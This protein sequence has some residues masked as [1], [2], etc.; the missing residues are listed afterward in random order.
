MSDPSRR[1]EYT[2]RLNR[3]L[4]HI[5]THLG[6]ELTL[7]ELARVACFSKYHFHRLFRSLLGEN[8]GQFI[9]R[10]RLERAAGYLRQEPHKPITRIAYD[11]GFASSAAF[12]RA[13]R[14]HFRCSPS[15]F[16]RRPDAPARNADQASRNPGIAVSNPEKALPPA[17][18]HI[19]Y[20]LNTEV[21]RIDMETAQRVV[22][23]RESP[24][25]TVAYVRHVGPYKGDA[26]L[27]ERLFGRLFRWAGPRNLVRPGESQ[28]LI[29][30]H[31]N[32]EI[33]AEEKLRVSVCLTVPRGTQGEGE[34]GILEIPPGKYAVTRFELAQDEFQ[35][36]WDWVYGTWLPESGYAPDDR[37]CFETYPEEPRPDG[38]FIVDIYAPVR[39]L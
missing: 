29:I 18:V 34:V 7:E 9:Q 16:R 15:A 23:V 3:V 4:D 38:T 25:M 26:K 20:H 36:A 1:Q 24:A 10:L 31:D 19:E 11:C 30:Y 32:P 17:S 37:P 27:F 6:D 35:Q 22:E 5:E 28:T 14:A 8:L 39:P 33:T 2:A 13:F 21:W 12:T